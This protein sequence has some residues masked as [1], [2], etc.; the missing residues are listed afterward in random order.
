MDG[1]RHTGY[2]L[3]VRFNGHDAFPITKE[4]LV[5]LRGGH[6]AYVSMLIRCMR[7]EFSAE[8]KTTIEASARRAMERW[9]ALQR[10]RSLGYDFPVYGDDRVPRDSAYILVSPLPVL[11]YQDTVA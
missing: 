9:D 2:R 7:Q 11:D 6:D 1:D 3:H 4:N 10:G 5:T 8:M